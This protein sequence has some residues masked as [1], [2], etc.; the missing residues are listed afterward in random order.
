[1]ISAL[2][3]PFSKSVWIIPAHS[4]A[5]IPFLNVQALT[6]SFPTVK[7]VAKPKISYVAV[8]NLFSPDSSIPSE[9][10]VKEAGKA[11]LEG[12]DYLMQDGDIC[13]FRF[14]V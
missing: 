8:I 1:M 3:K 14:N 12:K 11:R 9:L 10:K 4:L 7:Y 13:H 6:S 2:I 5:F